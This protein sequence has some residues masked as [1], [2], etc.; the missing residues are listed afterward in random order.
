[1]ARSKNSKE[2][3]TFSKDDLEA[4]FLLLGRNRRE[5]YAEHIAFERGFDDPDNEYLKMGFRAFCRELNKGY[6]GSD[7]AQI[8]RLWE[9]PNGEI[10]YDR[11]WGG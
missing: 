3:M 2:T 5:A 10:Y 7:C 11:Y 8:A 6:G 9:A 4:G 1:M